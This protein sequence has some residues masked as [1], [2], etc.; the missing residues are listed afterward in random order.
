MT[1]TYKISWK[2]MLQGYVGSKTDLQA[3]NSVKIKS[4]ICLFL[5]RS[6]LSQQSHSIGE[7]MEY[8]ENPINHL[9]LQHLFN[10]NIIVERS[11]FCLSS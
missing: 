6:S 1:D 9:I 11:L 10:R 8:R 4:S 3:K 5:T 7:L 2:K